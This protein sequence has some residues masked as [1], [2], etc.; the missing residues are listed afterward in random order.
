MESQRNN[1]LIIGS[2]AVGSLFALILNQ[3]GVAV[4]FSDLRI[5]FKEPSLIQCVGSLKDKFGATVEIEY[6]GV[7]AGYKPSCIIS[8]AKYS[9]DFAD[10]L[11]K[12]IET[13]S[14]DVPIL[15]LQNSYRHI[16]ELRERLPNFIVAGTLS[17]LET[18]FSGKNLIL[19]Q[20]P[21]SLNLPL[22]ECMI[23]NQSDLEKHFDSQILNLNVSGS[24]EV[25]IW[26]KLVRWVPLSTITSVCRLPIGE[27]LKVFPTRLLNDLVSETCSLAEAESGTIFEVSAIINQLHQLPKSLT[28]SSMRDVMKGRAPELLS[29]LQDM[30][31]DLHSYQLPNTSVKKIVELLN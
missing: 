30:E 11:M 22:E 29:V 18:F 23:C 19:T 25:V 7:G 12:S 17:Q 31:K 27:A 5:G 13:V 24:E 16:K 21:F 28:T 14:P 3:N 6:A 9:R 8:A 15:L 4:K 2:G 20:S 26:T 1:F 10:G